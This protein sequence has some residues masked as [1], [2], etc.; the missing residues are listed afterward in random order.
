MGHTPT[1]CQLTR[2]P[3]TWSR[4][5][6]PKGQRTH[7]VTPNSPRKRIST[8]MWVCLLLG[9]PPPQ[10]KKRRKQTPKW[11]DSPLESFYKP[12]QK[13]RAIQQNHSQVMPPKGRRSAI[14]RGRVAGEGQGAEDEAVIHHEASAVGQRQALDASAHGEISFVFR[15][16]RWDENEPEGNCHVDPRQVGT[17]TNHM[18]GATAHNFGTRNSPGSR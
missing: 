15:R 2:C 7:D 5:P 3:Q 1:C 18:F 12:T 13:R 6:R 17:C 4:D 8:H 14:R 16:V 11:L 9:H 10:K